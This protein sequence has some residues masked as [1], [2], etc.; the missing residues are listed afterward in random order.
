[1]RASYE[2]D[3]GHTGSSASATLTVKVHKPKV[4]GERAGG[5]KRRSV[6]L[7]A[8]LN[9]G[10]AKTTYYFQYGTS[11]SYRSKTAKRTLKAGTSTKRLSVLIK[12]LKPG[13]KYHF[14]LMAKN[15]A[16]SVKGRDVTFRTPTH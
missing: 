14:R 11:K 10:G 1:V 7:H 8:K 5:V 4:S 6:T 3:G 15:S 9:G 12:G 16:G 13:R 2:G